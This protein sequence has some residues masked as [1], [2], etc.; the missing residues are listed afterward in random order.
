MNKNKKNTLDEDDKDIENFLFRLNNS[1]PKT[2]I[3]KEKIV[4]LKNGRFKFNQFKKMYF[5]INKKEENKSKINEDNN[6]SFIK[7]KKNII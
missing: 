2:K 3:N 6:N 7:N 4:S 5:F 1:L